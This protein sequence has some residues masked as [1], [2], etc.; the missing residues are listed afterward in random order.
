MQN[1]SLK[2]YSENLTLTT[3]IAALSIQNEKPKIGFRAPEDNIKGASQC[4]R[5]SK[6]GFKD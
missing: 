3:K 1:E 4:L 6:L 2:L 5:V